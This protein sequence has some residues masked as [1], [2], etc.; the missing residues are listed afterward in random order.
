MS[1]EWRNTEI[2]MMALFINAG[3]KF[4]KSWKSGLMYAFPHRTKSSAQGKWY[5]LQKESYLIDSYGSNLNPNQKVIRAKKLCMELMEETI[6]QG[7]P[8][9]MKRPKD[10]TY[11]V[12]MAEE[13]DYDPERLDPRVD[14]GYLPKRLRSRYNYT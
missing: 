7:A 8:Q 10:R 3:W 4:A 5:G 14:Y 9:P 13:M 1:P 6:E 2:E 12:I 11:E